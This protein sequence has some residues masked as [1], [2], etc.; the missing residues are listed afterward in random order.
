MK[1]S[2]SPSSWRLPV[3]VLL[4]VLACG[5][6]ALAIS[7]E[8]IF[9]D[10]PFNLANP[11]ARPLALGGAF[12][13]LAD[14]STSAQANPAGLIGLRRP[15]LFAELRA[16][17]YDTSLTSFSTTLDGIFFQ[18]DVTAS[19]SSNPQGGVSPSFL[20]YVIPFERVALGFS[21]LEALNART[22]T[23]NS[24]TIQGME[25]IVT[26]DPVT[27]DRTITGFQPVD[28]ELT[29]DA[30]I[31]AQIVQYNVAAA[32]ELHQRLS[33]GLT[34]V[35][36]TA[37]VDGRVD[38][39]F[40]DVVGGMFVEPTLDYATRINDSDTDLTYNVGLL[41]R[42]ASWANVGAVYRKGSRFVLQEEIGDLGVRAQL[43]KDVFGS[44]F[45]NIIH[46]PDSYGLGLS[47]R[48]AEPWTLL[49]DVVRVEYSDLL[50]GY[51][52]GLNR[53]SFPSDQAEFTVDDGTEYHVGLE[54]IFLSGTTPIAMRFGAWSDPDHRIRA[55]RSSDLL[56]VFPAGERV[57]HYSTGFGMTF[58]QS[59]QLDFALDVSSA[60]STFLFST[61]YRF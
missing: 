57:M 32:F 6:A 25:A 7:D 49:L 33:L 47:F 54:K 43:A 56:A 42:P 30:D 16:Q 38:N 50:D 41:W 45:D 1:P 48:P 55:A 46:V 39:M 12:V 44:T 8:E 52:G 11:G 35:L 18:G 19:A 20:S 40:T 36:G 31:D 59:I 29:A 2:N 61:I 28:L 4:T 58:K 15:E 26:V 9:R 14:D 22:R 24:F 5:S 13:S 23:Q 3:L 21:R 60:N 53:I 27:G 51:V 34:A 17:G 10:F 37:E